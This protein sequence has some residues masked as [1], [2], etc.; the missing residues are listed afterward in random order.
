MATSYDPGDVSV[1]STPDGTPP[2]PRVTLGV[3]MFVT[4][5]IPVVAIRYLTP[6]LAGKLLTAMIPLLV[7]AVLRTS[8]TPYTVFEPGQ[9]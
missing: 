1:D 4:A 7:V 2:E 5:L 9:P 3:V 6:E 8:I